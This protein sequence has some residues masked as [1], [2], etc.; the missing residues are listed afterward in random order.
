MEDPIFAMNP[1]PSL[2]DDALESRAGRIVRAGTWLA[3]LAGALSFWMLAGW[4]AWA[5]LR[6]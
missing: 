1:G 4:M 5:F 2:S 6:A 3:I